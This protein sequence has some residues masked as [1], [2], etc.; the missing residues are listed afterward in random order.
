MRVW[1]ISVMVFAGCAQAEEPP[2]LSGDSASEAASD[3]SS[4]RPDTAEP[5]DT[6]IEEDVVTDTGPCKLVINE[7][8][9]GDGTS[10][11]ADFIELHNSCDSAKAIGNYKLVYRSN[12]GTTDTVLFTFAS[13]TTIPGKGYRVLGGSAFT[14]SKD[15]ALPSG[16]SVGGG[17]VGLRDA[18]DMLLDSVGYG[19]GMGILIEG[20]AAAAPGDVTPAKSIARSP[21]GMDTD[22][23]ASDFKVTTPTPGAAN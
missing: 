16:L 10:G 15:G 17:S 18:A 19:T 21:N 20:T 9:T 12:T 5:T 22:N 3:T 11:N 7:L 6:T 8:Q 1:L 13:G 23:N 14:G 2:V 4:P